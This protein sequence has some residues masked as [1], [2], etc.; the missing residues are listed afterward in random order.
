MLT[1]INKYLSFTELKSFL[2]HLPWQ[3]FFYMFVILA[4]LIIAKLINNSLNFSYRISKQLLKIDNK[5]LALSFAGYLTGV[6]II[7]LSLSSQ[8]SNDWYL[9]LDSIL[10]NILS[11]MVWTLLGIILLNISKLINDKILFSQFSN[12][13]EIIHDQNMGMGIIQASTYI[14]SAIIIEAILF[15]ETSQTWWVEVSDILLFFLFVHLILWGFTYIYQLITPYDIHHKLEKDNVAVG[16]S[17]S[18]Y[19]ISLAL[20]VNHYLY[21]T[22]NLLVLL[23]WVINGIVL[24]FIFRILI[25]KAFF[26][27]SD[28]NKEIA[29]DNN[30]GVACIEAALM[31]ALAFTINNAFS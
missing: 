9:S 28:L 18:G 17:L 8:M 26:I 30:W 15:G 19:F 7:I 10:K 23:C 21:Q 20:I 29:E 25:D 6:F 27:G 2:E 5:A 11:L 13:K 22:Y 3:G 1:I 4:I 12:T 16:V 14:S 31:I 24:M